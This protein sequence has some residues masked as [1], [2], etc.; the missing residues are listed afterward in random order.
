MQNSNTGGSSGFPSAFSSGMD[1]Y[2]GP[3]TTVTGGPSGTPGS[4]DAGLGGAGLGGVTGPSPG[5]A[6]VVDVASTGGGSAGQGS[7]PLIASDRVVGTAVRRPTGE[8]VG[9]IER[10]MLDKV[11]GRVAYA[12]MSFGGFLGLGQDHYALPW[13]RLRYNTDLDAY[14][15][16]ISE[17]E[18]RGAPHQTGGASGQSFDRDYETKL[19]DYY[20]APPYWGI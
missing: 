6:G 12:V 20:K 17:E 11:S 7:N 9:R 14:E 2:S 15:L 3:Q 18:L 8:T 13:S 16:D 5:L 10:L 4:V 19:H 1:R